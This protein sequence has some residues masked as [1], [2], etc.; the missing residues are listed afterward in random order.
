MTRAT[1][2][3]LAGAMLVASC[4]GGTQATPATPVKDSAERVRAFEAAEDEVLRDL[5]TLDRR[6]AQR[7]RITP[8]E[9]DLRRVAMDAVLSED[10]SV[11]V[12]DGAI[13]PFS[14]DAR[15]RGL[16]AVKKKVA[17]MPRDLPAAAG[18][19][20][21]A[22]AFERELLARLVD[23]EVLR[24]E[25]ERALPRS[26]SALVR[27]VVETWSP[28]RSPTEIGERDRWIARRL[29]EVRASMSN[30]TLGTVRAR[31][32]D[33]ALDALEHLVDAPGFQKSTAE[34]VRVRE[35]LEAQGSRP[36]D[37]ARSEWEDVARR[38]RAHLG[39][40]TTADALERDLDR[41]E[42]ELKKRAAAA[43]EAAHVGREVLVPRL[44]TMV[45]ARGDCI[46]AVPGSRVRSMAATDER[47]AACHLR[48]VVASAQDETSR[49]I[50]LAAMHDHVV[51]AQWAL[52][53]ARGKG[54]LAQA[55]N[56]HALFALADPDHQA[57]LERIAQARPVMAIAAG[58]AV[59]IL[60]AS[61]DPAKQAR[62]WNELGDVP[63]DV[64]RKELEPRPAADERDRERPNR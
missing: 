45:F 2:T 35:V 60:L 16:D 23:E 62:A 44:S 38:M 59:G 47:V 17:A 24:L 64:A 4:G 42:K 14:F 18:G 26:A 46:D 40:A 5:A 12:V 55:T 63:I 41:A 7:A 43:L 21:P 57:R 50:A 1:L 37:G 19:M 25:E 3:A 29:G 33:D 56:A 31:E 34:L 53:V 58:E 61:G 11:A 48:H 8:R 54:A 49:A 51:V 10:P 20:T 28:P 32:L 22:P 15:A 30:A 6:V 39:S 52:D 9:D 13:D 36:P 27:A